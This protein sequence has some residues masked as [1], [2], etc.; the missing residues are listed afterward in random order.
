MCA[1]ILLLSMTLPQAEDIKV[2]LR[3]LV[4][5]SQAPAMP[6]V[7]REPAPLH[8]VSVA[9]VETRGA[10]PARRSSNAGLRASPYGQAVLQT[11]VVDLGRPPGHSGS[12][13]PEG[14]DGIHAHGRAR[15]SSLGGGHGSGAGAG[16]GA[17]RASGAFG[18]PRRPRRSRGSVDSGS[19]RDVSQLRVR[20]WTWGRGRGGR[21]PPLVA[22]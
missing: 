3:Q 4:P 16:A 18:V 2:Y 15:R 12:A 14:V 6:P 21:A 19:E 7:P 13:H 17:H 20:V 22:L 8:T 1:C 11:D 9:A 5:A 10:G